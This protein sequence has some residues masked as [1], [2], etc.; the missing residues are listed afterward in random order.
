MRR[1]IVGRAVCVVVSFL[2]FWPPFAV[3]EELQGNLIGTAFAVTDQGHFVTAFHVVKGQSELYVVNMEQKKLH[4][5]ELLA[6]DEANDL[7]LLKTTFAAKP[8]RLS[9]WSSVPTGLEVFV[10]G[11]PQPKLLGTSKKITTGIINGSRGSDNSRL[12]Q[13]SAEV[14]K[15]NSGGPVLAPDGSVVGVVTSK[16]NALTVAEK[17]K[18]LPQNVNFALKSSV[19]AEFLSQNSI[20]V[21]AQV[22]DLS[23]VN[24]PY[25]VFKQFGESVVIVFSRGAQPAPEQR[26]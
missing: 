14:Q 6:S 13:T 25:E 9:Q 15:G 4:R 1:Y 5:A 23:V 26:R 22:L 3:A 19:L 11:Y 21:K 17:T 2:V 24:R 18:D 16:L 7:A 8:L 20:G 12:F 10:I